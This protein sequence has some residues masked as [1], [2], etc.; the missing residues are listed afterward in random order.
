[1]AEAA[2]MGDGLEVEA[3]RLRNGIDCS[4]RNQDRRIQMDIST[5]MT[6]R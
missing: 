3:E 5:R 2:P 6:L 1:M 4:Q